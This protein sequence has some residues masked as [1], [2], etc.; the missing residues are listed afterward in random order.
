[1]S[2]VTLAAQTWDT[3]DIGKVRSVAWSSLG[4]ISDALD[5]D[6]SCSMNSVEFVHSQLMGGCPQSPRI[7]D[8]RGLALV[9]GDM[10]AERG[11]FENGKKLRFS[12]IDGYDISR[13]SM[14]KYKP[15]KGVTFTAH[16][17][18]CNYL[19]LPQNQY[20][21]AVA[22]HGAHHVYNLGNFFYQSNKALLDNGVFFMYEWIGPKRLQIPVINHILST[23]LLW[24][25]F[26]KQ[27]RTTHMGHRKG[28]WVQSLPET[29]E[30]SEACNSTELWQQYH[31]Y[32]DP[33]STVFHGGLCYTVFEG[34]A[35]NLDETNS[36]T[37]FRISLIYTLEKILTKLRV[38]K[39][40]FVVS[41]GR[42]RPGIF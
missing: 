21:L 20:A 32:F 1:M 17:Q 9:C 39:P 30:P 19:N 26:S 16:V 25:L 11:L 12:A 29:F 36:W 33:I 3:I 2:N 23:L 28:L 40:L 10:Q 27:E 34:I 38:I 18:D 37:S 7:T 31:T 22:L 42:K 13:E 6:F 41:V 14:K 8:L 35:Q 24:T 4:Y 5:H 15:K